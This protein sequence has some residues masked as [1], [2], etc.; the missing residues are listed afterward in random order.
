MDVARLG[1]LRKR[2]ILSGEN[3]GFGRVAPPG[4]GVSFGF[5]CRLD[6]SR[7]QNLSGRCYWVSEHHAPLIDEGH[8]IL[9]MIMLGDCTLQTTETC[10]EF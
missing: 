5:C 6:S 7:V 8:P 1:N 2:S 4:D 9:L 10:L 3:D